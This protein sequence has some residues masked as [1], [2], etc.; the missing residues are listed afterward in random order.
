MTIRPVAAM[1][2]IAAFLFG[3]AGW[4]ADRHVHLRVPPPVRQNVA[5]MPQIIDPADAA[6]SRI[7]AA[8][9]QLDATVRKA[10]NDCKDADNKP[11]YWERTIDVPMRGPGFIS[12]LITDSVDCGGAHP[13]VSTMSIVYDL[14]SGTPVDWTQLLP[15]SL[16]GTP[17]LQ[18][19][20]DGTRMITLASQRL[21]ELYLAEYGKLSTADADCRQVIADSGSSAPPAMMAWL[22]AKAGGLAVQ[23]DLPHAVQACAL[24][25]VIP[26]AT[27][28]AEGAQ[29]ALL[30]A[31][32]QAKQP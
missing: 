1:F 6:E 29:P 30:D 10:A 2:L 19:G 31:V 7:N 5:S 25:V 16:T 24:P 32:Q 9:G 12:F 4:A 23:F 17:A 13:N 21:F 3:S 20:A 26:L 28:R 22:D 27:L 11:G 15:A 18:Q 8:L 14:R